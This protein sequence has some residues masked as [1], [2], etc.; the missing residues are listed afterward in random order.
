MSV[1]VPERIE[2][3]ITKQLGIRY[4]IV[5]APMFLVSSPSLLV[6]VAKAGGIG[7][8]PS[9]NFRTPEGYRDFLAQFPEGVPFG[10]NLALKLS[11]RLAE[12]IRLTIEH[13]VPLVVSSLGDP[14]R[15]IEAVHSYGG[16][17][18]CDVIGLRHAQ[19]AARAGADALIAVGSGAGG[20]AGNVSPLVL[21]PWLKEELGIPVLMAGALSRG[22]DLLAAL[23]LGCDGGYFGTRFIATDEA[24]ADAEYKRALLEAKPEDLEYT[25]E[26]TGVHGNFLKSSLETFRKGEGKAWKNIWSAGHGVAFTQEVLPAAKLVEQLVS[27]YATAYATLPALS[28]RG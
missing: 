17:V 6:E 27:D 8:I 20:H 16:K 1:P 12:D 24:A 10:I 15:I 14:T 5:A 18:W 26:V 25:N 22:R 9:L 21:G 28:S 4:P 19:K 2:T 7:V 13:K 3:A 11:D 23:S